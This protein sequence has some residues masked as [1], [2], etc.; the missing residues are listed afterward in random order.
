MTQSP[1]GTPDVVVDHLRT[2]AEL[3]EAS[4]LYRAVFGYDGSESGLNRRLLL[5][6]AANGGA[7]LGARTTDGR[8]VA[9]GY[10]FPGWDGS[11]AWFYSQAVV[12]AADAQGLGLG[13]R[14]KHAQ[15]LA[16]LER[17]F[18][19]M[20]WSFDPLY[21]RNAHLNLDVLGAVGRWLHRDL[22]ADGD[23]D[24]LVVEWDLT[25]DLQRDPGQDPA[26]RPAP[27]AP[28]EPSGPADWGRV[29][30]HPTLPG[31]AAVP[32]PATL[33]VGSGDRAAARA[34]GARVEDALAGLLDEGLAAV[35]CVRLDAGTAVYVC[36]A[37]R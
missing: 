30:R 36:E 23:S 17:G 32:F 18:T 7:A 22:Y 29:L 13:R 35:S 3:D 12:V 14:L 8:L 1:V 26:D 21:A 11:R 5:A 34:T 9:F 6:L 10:G 37:G 2:A 24:R 19:T 25:R 20:R 15:R 4:H 28:W 16:A 31:V 33:Q 27:P